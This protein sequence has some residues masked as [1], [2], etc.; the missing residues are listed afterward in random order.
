MSVREDCPNL[1]DKIVETLPLHRAAQNDPFIHCAHEKRN[2]QT[3]A[4]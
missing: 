2:Q 3:P 1:Q 4:E